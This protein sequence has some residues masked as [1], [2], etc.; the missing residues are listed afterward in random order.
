MSE[1]LIFTTAE[2]THE[3]F[4]FR[5]S[6][7]KSGAL[8]CGW[9]SAEMKLKEY[10]YQSA[11]QVNSNQPT[12]LDD[13][14]RFH[15]KHAR[16]VTLIDPYFGTQICK[17]ESPAQAL[18]EFFSPEISEVSIYTS[19]PKGKLSELSSWGEWLDSSG[20][21]VNSLSTFDLT[22]LAN[23][24]SAFKRQFLWRLQR[25]LEKVSHI[26]D[27]Q[28]IRVSLHNAQYFPHDRHLAFSFPSLDDTGRPIK[29]AVKDYF[30]LGN[31]LTTLGY[32]GR[33]DRASHVYHSDTVRMWTGFGPEIRNSS[34]IT[35]FIKNAG[36]KSWRA[37]DVP[38]R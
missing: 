25:Q 27:I 36:E 4:V 11:K 1:T 33:Y 28:Q 21:V 5:E 18:R 31:G 3:Y 34:F 8:L 7:S 19:V 26:S 23:N 17:S 6:T 20:K 38:D 22:L 9:G 30:S 15:N 32:I 13:A 12:S 10:A 16:D 14:V 35:V 29:G 37:Q 24:Q 2:P